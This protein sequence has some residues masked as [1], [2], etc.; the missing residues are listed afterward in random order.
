MNS[1]KTN[2]KILKENT[3]HTNKKRSSQAI[4]LV[5]LTVII[6]IAVFCFAI[7]AIIKENNTPE[8]NQGNTIIFHEADYEYDI[9]E[10]DNYLELDR[11]VRFENTHNGLTVEI[12]DDNLNDV[13]SD[14]RASFSVINEFVKYAIE[15]KHEKLN[16]LFSDEYIDADGELKM[17][18]TM[19]QL[20]NIKITYINDATTETDGYSYPSQDFWLE[21]M[22]RKNNGTFR[23]DMPSDCIKKEYVRITNRNG[24]YRIDVLS[25]YKTVAPQRQ[26]T[27]TGT[28][29]SI[30]AVSLIVIS[31]VIGVSVFITKKYE[32]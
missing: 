3:K 28:I 29:I 24:N 10:D 2:N 14:I 21:Y 8:V 1:Q 16:A 7:L 9:F 25:P 12:V 27:D 23:N 6:G 31:G 5:F 4:V 26:Q 22:I 32:K 18:F 11:N 19:Q 17:N 20:Y 13:P 15:G 30:A